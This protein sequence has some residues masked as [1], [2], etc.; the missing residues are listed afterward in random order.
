MRPCETSASRRLGRWLG[1]ALWA[2]AAA[3]GA[4]ELEV[5]HHY[6]DSNGV[7]IHYVSAGDGPLVVFIHG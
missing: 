4:S 2:V 3:G 6:A 1:L 5:S 7:K